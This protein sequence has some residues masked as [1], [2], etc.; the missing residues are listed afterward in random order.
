M[1]EETLTRPARRT[2]KD[3]DPEMILDRVANI[4]SWLFVPLLT[5]VYAMILIFSLSVLR[6]TTP[7]A[8]RVIVTLVIFGLTCIAPMII[9][10]LLK[11]MKLISDV[12]LNV[13]SE[14]PIPY[15]IIILCYLASARYLYIHG[16][17]MWMTMFFCGGAIAGAINLIINFKWKISAHAAGMAG[18]AAILLRM[19]HELPDT[20]NITWLVIWLILT[21]ILGASRIW[22]RRHTLSQVLAGYLNGFLCV[23]LMTMVN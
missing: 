14:R 6:I 17:P 12:G 10:L 8:T 20:A 15:L 11:R 22:L 4:F 2:G 23:W 7:T 9:F 21:G 18:V 1:S 13:R 5:P 19:A 3:A 16:A